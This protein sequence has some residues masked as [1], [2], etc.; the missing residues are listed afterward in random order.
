MIYNLIFETK[1]DLSYSNH[2][3]ANALLNDMEQ[4]HWE[5]IQKERQIELAAKLKEFWDAEWE[6]KESK[7]K[8][9]SLLDDMRRDSYISQEHFKIMKDLLK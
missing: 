8:Y 6:M 3:M 9:F 5:Q 7:R 2:P 1:Y 4:F